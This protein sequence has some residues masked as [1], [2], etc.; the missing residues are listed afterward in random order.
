M[1]TKFYSRSQFASWFEEESKK[2]FGHS[3]SW[4]APSEYEKVAKLILR[5][6]NE[7]IEIPSPYAIGSWAGVY[8]YG[9]KIWDKNYNY[10]NGVESP[11]SP[12]GSYASNYSSSSKSPSGCSS[13]SSRKSSY[14]SQS[15][16]S[17]SEA[18]SSSSATSSSG[19]GIVKR[20]NF[21]SALIKIQRF[22]N[23]V[24][25]I[26]ELKKFDTDGGLFGLGDHY[27]NGYEMNNY[28]EK[29]QD[30]FR[31]HNDIIIRTIQEFRDVYSTFDYLDK[32]YLSGIVQTAVAAAKASEGAKTASN[33]AKIASEQAKSAADKALKN[34][35]DLKKDVEN[36]RKLVEKIRSIKEDLSSR[37]ESTNTSLSHKLRKMEQDLSAQLLSK[38]QI[39]VLQNQLKTINQLEK[40]VSDWEHILINEVDALTQRIEAQKIIIEELT[41]RFEKVEKKTLSE[42]SPQNAQEPVNNSY[43]GLIWAYIT[44][45][46]ALVCS[47]CSLVLR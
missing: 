43:T 41:K 45:G 5:K 7:H 17:F 24:P 42:N 6:I 27:I 16:S 10:L 44:G 40:K 19:I 13:Q 31:T 2:Y 39:I 11:D 28:V 3:G 37:I 33:Q 36:L 21:D 12:A 20:H 22:S 34:E 26:P 38:D 8:R 1:G 46:L 4:V 18:S 29:V 9:E 23:E 30:I 32:E 25:Y 47:I 15:S 14:E 35:A